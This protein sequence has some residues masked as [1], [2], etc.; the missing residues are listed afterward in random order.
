[1]RDITINLLKGCGLILLISI[2]GVI[3]SQLITRLMNFINE[4][5]S[6]N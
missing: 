6:K 3:I 5:F 1:M 4:K 2:T